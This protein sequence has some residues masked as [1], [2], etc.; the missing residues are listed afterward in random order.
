MK[1]FST[2]R[3]KRKNARLFLAETKP[4]GCSKSGFLLPLSKALFCLENLI[5]DYFCLLFGPEAT[6]SRRQT[7][8]GGPRSQQRAFMPARGNKL[9]KMSG[10]DWS[11]FTL[12]YC[13]AW[14]FSISL[15][16]II[17]IILAIVSMLS[18]ANR[19]EIQRNSSLSVFFFEVR[20]RSRIRSCSIL[21]LCYT[22]IQKVFSSSVFQQAATV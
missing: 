5:Y 13:Q 10:P 2:L 14:S 19:C 4:T 16:I 8:K 1:M 11:I 20:F 21:F 7:T 15:N 3:K 22:R 6:I 18:C 12:C 17:I 9:H